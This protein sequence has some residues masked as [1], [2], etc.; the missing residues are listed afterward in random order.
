MKNYIKENKYIYIF[1]FEIFAKVIPT[2]HITYNVIDFAPSNK[3][4]MANKLPSTM[5]RFLRRI[6][7]LRTR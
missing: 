7:S 1:Q 3:S 4:T 6:K 5:V 2:R